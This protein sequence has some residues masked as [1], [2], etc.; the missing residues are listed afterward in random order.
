MSGPHPQF[1]PGALSGHRRRRPPF[2]HGHVVAPATSALT[3]H[4][5]AN[6]LDV[7]KDLPLRLRLR[8][9]HRDPVK[10]NGSPSRTGGLAAGLGDMEE[11]SPPPS[12]APRSPRPRSSPGRWTA[13][14]IRSPPK[15]STATPPSTSLTSTRPSPTSTSP[16]P[17]CPRFPRGPLWSRSQYLRHFQR[18]QR[19]RQ[20][21]APRRR[22]RPGRGR[23]EA[24]PP[25]A[26]L[27]R[28][29]ADGCAQD[30][31]RQQPRR[32][33]QWAFPRALIQFGWLTVIAK[34]L[35][36]ALR[37][38]RGLLGPGINNWGWAIIIV[39]VLFNLLMLPTRLMMMKSSLKMMRIQ[40]KVEALKKRYAISR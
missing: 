14:R 6:G 11:F 32:Q 40:P 9:R 38:L 7:L 17:S 30:H 26:P 28:P 1:E 29:K 2:A 25:P 16:R 19:P 10:R 39:T 5:A 37:F 34:P 36:L 33:P 22:A 12:P 21:E 35:Y 13:S 8:G 23:P 15:R 4:Y 27:R 24:A 20:P 18:P 3:F 31:P